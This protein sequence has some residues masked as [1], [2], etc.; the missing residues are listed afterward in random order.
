M[1]PGA[2]PSIPLLNRWWP[3][4]LLAIGLG[5]VLRIAWPLADPAEGISWSGGIYTDPPANTL[6]ARH[7]IEQGDWA[8]GRIPERHAYPLLNG[9]TWLA[10]RAS[11]VDRLP[12]QILAAMIGGLAILPLAAALRRVT[13]ARTAA[14]GAILLST[15]YWLTMYSRVHMAE[16]VAV[17]LMAVASW[18]AVGKG[19]RR[20]TAAAAVAVGALLFGKY[21]A[22]GFLPGFVLFLSL[23]DGVRRAAPPVL[24]GGGLVAVAWLLTVFLPAQAEIIAW[25]RTTSV[26]AAGP[27]SLPASPVA[28]LLEP[29]RALRDSWMFHQ[30]PAISTLGLFFVASTFGNRETLR[31]RLDDGSALFAFWF[32]GM[33]LYHVV[34]PYR[35]PRYFVLVAFPLAACAAGRIAD[36]V[37]RGER[38][39]R[40]ANAGWRALPGGISLLIVVFGVLDLARHLELW[41][42]TRFALD[43][44]IRSGGDPAPMSFVIDRVGELSHHVGWSVGITAL[45]LAGAAAARRRTGVARRRRRRDRTRLAVVTLGLVLA[46]NLGQ[47]AAWAGRRSYV[48]E[49]ARESLAGVVGPT[50]V[51]FGGFAPLL[52][53]GTGITAVPQFGSWEGVDAETLRGRGVTHLLLDPGGMAILEEDHPETFARLE[54]VQVWPM[55]LA[56][57]KRLELLRWRESGGEGTDYRL[58]RFEEAVDALGAGDLPRA[59]EIAFAHRAEGGHELPDWLI[60]EA[61]VRHRQGDVP[62]ARRLLSRA[63]VLRPND[64]TL[65]RNIGI[66]ALSEGDLAGAVALWKRGLRVDPT[67]GDLAEMIRRYDP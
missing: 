19:P 20:T 40:S 62:S 48:I 17:L 2:P 3:A 21:N 33:L 45:L 15:C 32:L 36:L 42:R 11:G 47:W 49:G 30:M 44:T 51:V 1:M 6:P 25:L 39:P 61:T 28:W 67:S 22:V 43:A 46:I 9:L 10:F 60:L 23:R 4:V 65:Y 50:A 64:P 34:T 57:V 14:I 41:A 8:F 29:F 59:L 5:L 18:L 55:R 56:W 26:G 58:T 12:M 13:G 66:L 16:N 63:L 53:L 24:L 35:A 38:P 31:R 52:S 27:S 7:A 37:A 54:P